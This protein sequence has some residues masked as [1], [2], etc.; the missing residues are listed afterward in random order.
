M[1]EIFVKEGLSSSCL[2]GLGV[3]WGSRT[4]FVG[5]FV[6]VPPE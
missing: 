3:R 5:S 2:S 6:F 4:F 1:L